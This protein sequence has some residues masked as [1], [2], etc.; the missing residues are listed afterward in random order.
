LGQK[1]ADEAINMYDD[2]TVKNTFGYYSVDWEGVRSRKHV[3][4]ERGILKGFMQNLETGSRMGVAPGGSARSQAYS[5]PPIIRM[6]NTYFGPGDWKK[7]ELIEEVGAGLL[8]KGS[9]YGYVEP[10]KGQFMFKCDEAYEIKNGEL[11]QRF[12]DASISGLILDVLNNVQGMADDFVLTDPGYCGKGGQVA[13]TTDGGPH[14]CV[15][16]MVVGGLT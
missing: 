13:R 7:D 16:N 8:V 12:R 10:A 9:Q 15:R 6:S 2:P 11:G 3:L 14:M 4:V 5:S 1:V